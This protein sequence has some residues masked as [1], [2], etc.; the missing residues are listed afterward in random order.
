M[1]AT[2]TPT[3]H[4]DFQA[5]E[6]HLTHTIRA[7]LRQIDAWE[8]RD[9]NVGADLET[10][11]TLA[12]NAEEKA[13]MLAVHVKEP[14]F[15]SLRVR[16]GGREQ[17]LYVGKHAFLDLQGP[18]SV[19][20]WE[21]AVGSLYYS[22]A[23]TW[24][25]PGRGQAAGLKGT[26]LRRRQLDVQDRALHRVTDLYDVDAGGDTGGREAVLLSRLSEAATTGMRDVVETL[27]PE[28]NDAMRA[29]AGTAQLI[30]G[31]AGSGKTTIGFHRLAWLMHPERAAERARPEACLVL[32]PNQVLAAYAARVLPGLNLQGVNVTTPESWALSFLGLE[33]MDVTDRT[34]TLLLQDRDNGRRRAAWRRAKALGD[35]RML[36][37]VRRHLARRLAVNVARLEFALQVDL[38]GETRS[39]QLGPH[40]LQ[41]LLDD[42]QRRSPLEGYRSAFRTAALER[43]LGLLNASG[44][45]EVTRVT[46]LLAPEVTALTG[47]VFA[48]IL[49]VSEGRRIVSDEATLRAAAD[50]LLD[51]RTLDV[52]L[53][54]PL[55]SVAKPR[56]SSADVTEIPL[57]LAVAALLDGVGRREGRE[58]APY[59]HIVLD[60]AQDYAPLLYALLARAA[61]PGHITALGDLNQG[62]HGYKGPG[63][64]ADVQGR[65]GRRGPRAPHHA[66]PHVPQHAADHAPVRPRRRDVQ[67]RGRRGRRGP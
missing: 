30:Q 18:H 61:R 58:V 45:A 19:V 1:P 3:T 23:L 40:D 38:R 62:L 42:V 56:R 46:R 15:G 10:S 6:T 8:D 21:S 33:K 54:D 43:V 28:Q 49:P 59:D 26:V 16:I 17:L 12:D 66:V 20:S 22:D 57:M 64:W 51:E 65:T 14:Y 13:A 24:T 48:G 2:A 41:G 63:R 50:G 67:P 5:E 4:P 47:K 9:R 55:T 60:E 31:A 36:E 32:M 11:L 29:P 44:D 37:V 39:V 25:A 7:V 27:Q 52:L 53:G 35:L 34:L